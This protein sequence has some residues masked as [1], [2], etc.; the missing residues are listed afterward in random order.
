LRSSAWKVFS[1]KLL[2]TTEADGLLGEANY[3]CRYRRLMH[4][5]NSDV[6]RGSSINVLLLI[7]YPPP[8]FRRLHADKN[9]RRITI[10]TFCDIVF[11]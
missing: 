11:C 8:S 7:A 3:V 9:Q 1:D 5:V 2:L 6:E 4:G 10:G